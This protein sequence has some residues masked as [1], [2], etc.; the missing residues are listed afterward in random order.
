MAS[1]RARSSSLSRKA[2]DELLLVKLLR[3]AEGTK[4]LRKLKKLLKEEGERK[5]GRKE[6]KGRKVEKKE[7]KVEKKE[8][9]KEKVEKRKGGRTASR[10][11]RKTVRKEWKPRYRVSDVWTAKDFAVEAVKRN[12]RPDRKWVQL[13]T[14][15]KWWNKYARF[16]MEELVKALK[17]LG[18]EHVLNCRTEGRQWKLGGRAREV[19]VVDEG[20]EKRGEKRGEKGGEAEAEAKAERGKAEGAKG[21][22]GGEKARE[23][24]TREEKGKEKE[25]EKKAV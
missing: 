16:D 10:V 11:G 1:S 25:R 22:K 8:K 6:E 3:K 13:R 14:L 21:E 20:G 12:L 23:E 17:A 7:R 24:R 4:E 2:R 5:S 9:E 15:G 19:I 18:E